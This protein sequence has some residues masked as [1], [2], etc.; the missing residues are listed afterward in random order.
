MR[1]NVE[2]AKRILGDVS[3]GNRFF[4]NDGKFFS[5]LCDLKDDIPNMSNE[6]F[7]HHTGQG[8]NDFANWIRDCL[9]DSKLADELVGLDKK[10]SSKKIGSRISYIE[11]YLAK[12][13]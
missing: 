6:A 2:T 1:L 9:G 3:E 10:D 13:G 5:N 7:L 4:C 11:K 12:K 8:R